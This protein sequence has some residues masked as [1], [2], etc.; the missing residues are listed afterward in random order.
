VGDTAET[1][2]LR[3]V[4][5]EHASA[6]AVSSTKSATGHQFGAAGAFEVAVCALA[7]RDGVVPPTL[8]YRD[9]DPTC[10]LDYVTEGARRMQVNVALSN[11]MGLG[12]HNGCVVVRRVEP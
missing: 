10:D 7:V 3:E 11:S 8:N 4:F 9:P 2:A 6:L 12:G 5:G 1:H